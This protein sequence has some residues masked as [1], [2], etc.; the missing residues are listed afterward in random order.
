MKAWIDRAPSHRASAVAL[1]YI[2]TSSLW[3][4]GMDIYVYDL[5]GQDEAG[6][7]WSG[8]AKG[9]AFIAGT[10]GLLF[11]ALR[12]SYG[13][14]EDVHAMQTLRF[15]QTITALARMVE[16]RDI[17][18]HGHQR[19]VAQICDAL[20]ARMQLSPERRMALVLAAELHDIGKIGVPEHLLNKAGFM[21]DEELARI[22]EHAEIG[23]ALL[24]NV[25]F[26]GPVADIVGQHHERM[27]GSGYPNGLFGEEILFEA[28]ILAVADVFEAMSSARPYRNAQ[29]AAVALAELRRYSGVKYDARVVAECESWYRERT[30]R[31][32]PYTAVDK[33]RKSS[34]ARIAP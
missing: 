5:G 17:Y 29:G 2:L 3:I 21:T 18:T 6:S 33:G 22:H 15:S 12:R 10:G 28:R 8:I 1:L 25:D 9:V 26:P 4:V 7:L 19:R 31:P 20:A 16:L 27:D 24:R 34:A 13:R 23:G 32:P 14:I 30:E 11:L